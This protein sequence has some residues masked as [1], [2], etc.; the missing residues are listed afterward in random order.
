[1]L[2]GGILVQVQNLITMNEV[3][4]PSPPITGLVCLTKK[5]KY[6]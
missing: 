3:F 6:D 1:M 2:S 5:Y 4:Y